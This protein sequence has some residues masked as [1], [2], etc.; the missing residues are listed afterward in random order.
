M[1]KLI[2]SLV[3]F[4]TSIFSISFAYSPLSKAQHS[5]IDQQLSWFSHLSKAEKRQES[6][7][8]L[9]L[10]QKSLEIRKAFNH[11]N[12]KIP[13]AKLT[14]E[15]KAYIKN[16]VATFSTFTPKKLAEEL[17]EIKETQLIAYEIGRS[18]QIESLASFEGYAITHLPTPLY[19]LDKSEFS[20]HK[21]LWSSGSTGLQL[22]NQ[23]LIR[24]LSVVLPPHSPITLISKHK[25]DGYTYYQVR[26]R[27]FDAGAWAKFAYFI[28]ERFVKK[29]EY[30]MPELISELPSS[31]QIIKNLLSAKGSAYVRGGS[32]YQWVW[33]ME[34][35]FPSAS[36]LSL[37]HKKQKNLNGVDCSWLIREATKGN[38]PRNTRQ[39]LSFWNPVEIETL[40]K[41]EIITKLK[42]L[43][44]IVW[45]WHVVLVLSP[46]KTIESRRRPNF[47]G[48]VE[49][50]KLENRLAEIMKTR[51]PVNDYATSKLAKSKKFVIRRWYEEK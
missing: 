11:G 20:I 29:T 1:K 21:I 35:F 28:D 36:P 34:D 44:L 14:S 43:D 27:E 23:N 39:L 22:D 15:D 48:G 33:E 32:R 49:I 41:E 38:T 47:Q 16:R 10:A 30:K 5:Y 9:R 4:L 17:N 31:K 45:D 51:T 25:I 13:W 42:P 37:T 46:N 40:N 6:D 3:L 18:L 50:S 7:F 8:Y 2:L 26:T 12:W 24:E 19:R